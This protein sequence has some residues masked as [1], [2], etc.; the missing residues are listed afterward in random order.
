MAENGAS[1]TDLTTVPYGVLKDV[2]VDD[3]Y[4]NLAQALA[5]KPRE[6]DPAMAAFLYFSKMGE[7]ASQPGATLFGSAAGAASSPAEYIMGVREANI[8]AEA[9]VPATAIN[10]MKAL[11]PTSSQLKMSNIARL[12]KE[13]AEG[14]INQEEFNKAFAKETNIPGDTSQDKTRMD[15]IMKGAVDDPLTTDIDERVGNILR[16]EFDSNLHLP[17]SSLD[18]STTSDVPSTQLAKLYSDLEKAEVGSP[19]REAIQKQIDA[20]I[21]KAGFDKELFEAENKILADYTKKTKELVESEI[22]Y[23]KLAEA[24]NAK[25]GVGDLAMVFS[26]MKM[27]DPGSVVR[28][29]EFS[30]AQN[31]AGL[32]Q[33]LLVAAE[34]IQKGDLLSEK[35]RTNFLELSKKFLEA[36]RLHMAKIRLDKGLQVKNYGLNPVNIFGSE[37]A[38]PSFYLDE[39]V[40]NAAKEAGITPTA[41][42][43]TMSDSEKA[44]YSEVGD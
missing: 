17:K 27:L 22:S 25:D 16:S 6:V 34:N 28:E 19:Q 37:I 10:L 1:R 39:E 24:R 13:L 32:F 3:K 5:G 21:T 33:K 30:A 43:I 11:K 41:M 26:F 29:S 31:T 36:G 12:K 42:W 15:V 40:Y 18:T 35:Q 8:K 23:N 38:P 7:L 44:S 4:I 14:T 20:E 2:G 9:D